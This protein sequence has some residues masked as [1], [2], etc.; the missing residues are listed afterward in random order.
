MAE[1]DLVE[2]VRNRTM[3]PEIAATL[4]ATAEQRRSFLVVAIPRLAGKTTVTQAMLQRVPAGTPLHTLVNHP[5]DVD[6][7]SSQPTGGYLVVPEVSEGPVP[8]YIWGE[9]ARRVFGLLDRGYSLAT[10]MHAPGVHEAFE[11]LTGDNAIPDQ[12]VAQLQ[13][14]VYIRTLGEDWQNPTRRVIVEVHEIEGVTGGRAVA[15]LLH[16]WDEDG[17]RFEQVA[18]PAGLGN[19]GASLEARA[20]ELRRDAEE[21]P[22]AG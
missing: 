9:P 21:R 12:Q 11:M 13:L 2:L 1:L 15:R 22:A 16:R 4:W 6:A 20:R 5:D 17:D 3:S 14:G 18:A 8:G 19:G 10:T 7:L